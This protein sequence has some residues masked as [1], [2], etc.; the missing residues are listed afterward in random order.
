[1]GPTNTTSTE[2][3]KKEEEEK[4]KEEPE[5]EP[6]IKEKEKQ[7]QVN[8]NS[9]EMDDAVPYSNADNMKFLNDA[10]MIHEEIKA[11]VFSATNKIETLQRDIKNSIFGR[12]DE[13]SKEKMSGPVLIQTITQFVNQ[14]E[15]LQKEVIS[16]GE[17][18]DELRDKIANILEKNK[19]LIE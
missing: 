16:K 5:P 4:K 9:Y 10:K 8:D 3:N 1:M 13:I 17:R 2:S 7:L 18:I 11:S 6:E 14:N 12:D 15:Q 19:L